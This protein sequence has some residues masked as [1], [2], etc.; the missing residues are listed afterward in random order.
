MIYTGPFGKWLLHGESYMEK[1]VE[2]VKKAI[3]A[4]QP[5]RPGWKAYLTDTIYVRGRS[6]LN[7]LI[8]NSIALVSKVMLYKL[9]INK[10][11][12]KRKC[13]HIFIVK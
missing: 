3:L 13:E 1:A 8:V 9:F 6:A 5:D 11:K 7:N 2:A 12:T 10:K 4:D